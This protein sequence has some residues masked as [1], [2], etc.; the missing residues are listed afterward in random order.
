M[1]F[2]WHTFLES[3]QG[4]E[5]PPEN[6]VHA[7]SVLTSLLPQN[8]VAEIEKGEFYLVAKLIHLIIIRKK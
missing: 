3:R 2:D 8:S 5:V 7:E 1:H 4:S 6:F